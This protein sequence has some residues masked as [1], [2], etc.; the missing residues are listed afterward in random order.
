MKNFQAMCKGLVFKGWLSLD[1]VKKRAG[2][3]E[4]V[5]LSNLCVV[6]EQ[7]KDFRHFLTQSL[8]EICYSNERCI[9]KYL[10]AGIETNQQEGTRCMAVLTELCDQYELPIE[11]DAYTSDRNVENAKRLYQFFK[12]FGF[13]FNRDHPDWKDA[14]N[15]NELKDEDFLYGVAMVRFPQQPI[16]SERREAEVP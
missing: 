7:S 5:T 9:L 13:T 15:E 3:T 14:D 1:S 2:G 8:I 12:R 10:H 6:P 11:L 16:F 4:E